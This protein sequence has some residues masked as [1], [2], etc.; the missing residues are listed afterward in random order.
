MATV[1]VAMATLAGACSPATSSSSPPPSA[2]AGAS[3]GDGTAVPKPT[4]WPTTVVEAAIALGAADGDFTTMANDVIAAVNSEDPARILQ[5][6]NDAIKFLTENQKNIPKMQAY[7]E[8]KSVGDRLEPAY[9]QMLKG[10]T[11]VRDGLTAG[12]TS[13]VETGLTTFFAGNDAYVKVSSDLGDLAEQALFMK[14][15]LLR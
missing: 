9:A 10:A 4:A 1:I 11:D 12:N 3:A 6:M 15:Q 7:P 8:T 14:R 2:S 13:A 5:V